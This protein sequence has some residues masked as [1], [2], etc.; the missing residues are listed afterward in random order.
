MSPY[1]TLKTNILDYLRKS[2]KAVPLSELYKS[3]SENTKNGIRVS[4]Y[5]LVDEGLVEKT[6][7]ERP[8]TYRAK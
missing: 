1:K 4:I 3:F 2:K 7:K 6:S 5:K 8:V